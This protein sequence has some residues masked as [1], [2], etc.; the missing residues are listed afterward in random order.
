MRRNVNRAGVTD[1]W[2]GYH[3]L[4]IGDLGAAFHHY[5]SPKREAP[6]EVIQPQRTHLVL[7]LSRSQN[8]WGKDLYYPLS[9][10]V[11]GYF[12]FILKQ[13]YMALLP[14]IY[15]GVGPRPNLRTIPSRRPPDV[16]PPRA[17]IISAPV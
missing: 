14:R 16:S 1:I 11:I 10:Y 9:H 6:T 17:A 7:G 12:F 4:I 3:K 2:V 8:T 5:Q 13:P 15:A